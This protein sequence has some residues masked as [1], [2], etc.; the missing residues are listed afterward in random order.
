MGIN[1]NKSE[2]ETEQRE[3]LGGVILLQPPQYH[4][5]EES[6]A[7]RGY[8][9]LSHRPRIHPIASPDVLHLDQGQSSPQ[10]PHLAITAINPLMVQLQRLPKQ[11]IRT[12][13][14]VS[15]GHRA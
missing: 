12:A 4:Q 8:P 3:A 14:M 1:A 11:V 10:I 2:K 9:S 6:L 7:R 15:N 13:D 5:Y